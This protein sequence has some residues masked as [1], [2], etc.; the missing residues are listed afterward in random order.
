MICL[1]LFSSSLVSL[2]ISTPS[3]PNKGGGT[4]P[5]SPVPV[6]VPVSP[7]VAALIFSCVSN[8]CFKIFAISSLT[9]LF[10]NK[11]FTFAGAPAAGSDCFFVVLSTTQTTPALT[12]LTIGRR[13]GNAYSMDLHGANLVVIKRDGTKQQVPF[14]VA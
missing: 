9:N 5:V 4:K 6:P 2:S 12:S 14:N 7:F 1:T 3:P 11:L 13:S 10:S 8:C